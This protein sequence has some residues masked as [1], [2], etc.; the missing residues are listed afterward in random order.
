MPET[1]DLGD[2][3]QV[4]AIR[5]EMSGTQGRSGSIW[6]DDSGRFVRTSFVTRGERLDYYPID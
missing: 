2:G 1:V 3:R 5:Y 4:A 6:Y